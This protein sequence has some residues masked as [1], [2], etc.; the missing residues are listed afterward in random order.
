MLTGNKNTSRSNSIKAT[1]FSVAEALRELKK[2]T[3]ELG[4]QNDRKVAP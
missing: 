2:G 1:R 4:I 3:D